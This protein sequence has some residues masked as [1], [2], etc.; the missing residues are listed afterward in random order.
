M[1]EYNTRTSRENMP[2]DPCAPD[3]HTDPFTGEV[4]AGMTL[5]GIIGLTDELGHLNELVVLHLE[6]AG[7]FTSPASYFTIVTPVLDMLEVEIRLRYRAGMSRDQVKLIVQ[8][9]IDKEI[10]E[11]KGRVPAGAPATDPEKYR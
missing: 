7:G 5:E 9:W 11:L 3:S 6:Q 8:D 4:P 2:Q 1:D 10:A